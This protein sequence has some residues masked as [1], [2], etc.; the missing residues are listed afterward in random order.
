MEDIIVCSATPE[1]PG[2][3][4]IRAHFIDLRRV[5]IIL[6][7]HPLWCNGAKALLFLREV[8]LPGRSEANGF[9]FRK[10]DVRPQLGRAL[11]HH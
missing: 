8:E 3:E 2:D 9:S 1:M 7:R 10:A 4:L 5:L 11:E 6:G